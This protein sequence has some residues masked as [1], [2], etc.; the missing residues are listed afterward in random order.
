MTQ[1]TDCIDQ[2][3]IRKAKP[4]DIAFVYDTFLNS[5]KHCSSLG[6]S[7]RSRVFFE[8]YKQ[9]IDK[10]LT[11]SKTTVACL[12]NNEDV[13]VGYMISSEPLTVHFIFIKEIFRDL[14]VATSLIRDAFPDLDLRMHN[15]TYTHRTYDGDRLI[16]HRQEFIY[17]P[18]LL[19]K[20]EINHV[21]S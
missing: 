20:K 1:T 9:V 18:F 13:I 12:P 10:L 3:I 7:C 5:V 6:K 17:N 8:E 19:Y 4:S 21:E 11:Q 2:W 16:R 14:G 15:L